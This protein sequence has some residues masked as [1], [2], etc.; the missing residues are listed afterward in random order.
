MGTASRPA[1]T[2]TAAAPP[3][4][5]NDRRPRPDG[6]PLRVEPLPPE[7]EEILVN[8][9]RSS[10]KVNRLSGKF[11]KFTYQHTFSVE[12]RAEGDFLYEAPDRGVYMVKGVHIQTGEKSKKVDAK[13]TPYDLKPDQPE[14]W[15]CNG[16]EIMRFNETDRTYESVS[17][18]PE[19]RGENI[20]DGPLPFLF[21]M[22]ADQAKRRYDMKLIKLTKEE[23]WISAIPRLQMDAANYQEAIVI[24]NLADYLPNAVKLVDPSGSSETVHRFGQMDIN[25]KPGL[26]SRDPFQPSLVGYKKVIP[27]SSA[28]PDAGKGGDTKI[29]QPTSRPPL[30]GKTVMNPK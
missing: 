25:R 16:S 8:W 9:E 4:T 11:I 15:I 19:N 7:L 17:I 22:R 3:A 13:G 5:P 18:P 23:A 14:R 30:A 6:Q 2:A 27:P 10:K 26:L 21:G 24:L 29:A 20:I 12:T 1:G 28:R